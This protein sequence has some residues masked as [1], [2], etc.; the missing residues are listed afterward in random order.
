MGLMLQIESISTCN[1]RCSFCVY[2]DLKSRW[3]NRMD[4]DLFKKIIDEAST[5]PQFDCVVIQGLGEPLL[6]NLLEERI[7]YTA[8][9]M[10]QVVRLGFFTNGVFLTPERW[11][12]LMAA[13]TTWVV[14]S[15]NANT[16]EQHEKVMGLKG[17]F[18]KV[19]ANLE[20]ARAHL[21]EGRFLQVDAVL[22]HDSFNK[23]DMLRFYDKWGQKGV[24]DGIG[25]CIWEGNWA[26]DIRSIQRG[27]NSLDPASCCSRAIGNIYVMYNGVVTTCCFD[28]TGKMIFGDLRTETIREMYNRNPYL[29]FREDHNTNHADRYDICK[30][31]S[32]I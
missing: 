5:I 4:M 29:K 23:Q 3:G 27:D 17:K 28:P 25:L 2:P 22:N 30:N 14:V 7:A 6:D 19:V 24:G 32:R 11:D 15:L 21:P 20:Y 1:A 26:G 13:G 16:A 10:P 8:E 18:D 12:A 31:C 9:R